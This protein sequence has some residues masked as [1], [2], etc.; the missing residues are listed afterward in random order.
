QPNQ[1]REVHCVLKRVSGARI[2]KMEQDN[3]KFAG[4]LNAYFDRFATLRLHSYFLTSLIYKGDTYGDTSETDGDVCSYRAGRLWN[5]F[6]QVILP[7][8][9]NKPTDVDG[10]LKIELDE[11][12]FMYNGRPK[13]CYELMF[14]GM[15]GDE[16]IDKWYSLRGIS[17]FQSQACPAP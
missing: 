1:Y 9:L 6:S 11:P 12:F 3:L 10:Q 8:I 2:P 4:A 17:F 14:H 5:A 16:D 7:P 13:D 15:D